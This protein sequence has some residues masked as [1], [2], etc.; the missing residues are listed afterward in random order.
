MANNPFPAPLIVLFF[1][2]SCF[3]SNAICKICCNS[4]T[5]HLAPCK[6]LPAH[7]YNNLTGLCVNG[8]RPRINFIGM[9][10]IPLYLLCLVLLPL[11]LL[12]QDLSGVW[13]GILHNDSTN[14]DLHYEIV[15]SGTGD[16]MTGYSYTNFIVN[17]RSY[18]GVKSVSVKK[19]FG[20]LHIEDEA[21]VY[22]NYDFEPP[23]GI[24][25]LS[26]LE[27]SNEEEMLFGNFQTSRTR[28]Y[29][30]VTGHIYLLKKPDPSVSKLMEIL[31]GI[32]KSADLSFVPKT[33]APT[34]Q[35]TAP[36]VKENKVPEKPVAVVTKTETTSHKE[37]VTKTP[38]A[39]T[40]KPVQP[41]NTTVTTAANKPVQATRNM[42]KELETRKV[43]T[44]QT[45]FFQSDSLV[46]ELYD[47]GYV[48]G[49]SVS[50]IVN[51]QPLFPN[52]RL[53]EKA[54][55]KQLVI[56]PSMGDSISLVMFAE[57]LGSIAPNSGL[58]II[59]DGKT[60]HRIT[61]SGDLQRNAGIILRR[62]KNLTE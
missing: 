18:T 51:N 20:K 62:K 58:A 32:Q 27:L 1:T 7:F 17:N 54:I 56:T 44:V 52:L 45:I 41:A 25:Q 39:E 22:N 12:A 5:I 49:D 26:I 3:S 8:W 61:F 30:P 55:L 14:L 9:V 48:D 10:R 57:N 13:V 35:A 53:S 28:Q 37:T 24:K 16:K 4:T 19:K 2:S 6:Y 43:E 33:T 50:I 36:V 40:T 23:K 34:V 38:A 59:R 60:Q 11:R 42:Q 21:L 15:I 29:A 47:N 31:T 46:L